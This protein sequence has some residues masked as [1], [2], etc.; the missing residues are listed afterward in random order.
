MNEIQSTKNTNLTNKS[1][2][3]KQLYQ[4]QIDAINHLLKY[5]RVLFGL[6]MGLGKTF[7]SL[8]WLKQKRLIDQNQ[9]W[10]LIICQAN[11]RQDWFNE[12]RAAFFDHDLQL[13]KQPQLLKKQVKN[14]ETIDQQ[15]YRVIVIESIKQLEQLVINSRNQQNLLPYLVIDGYYQKWIAGDLVN[16]LNDLQRQFN[17]ALKT[18]IITNNTFVIC[19]YAV[20]SAYSK[21]HRYWTKHWGRFGLIF[22]ESQGLR[23]H[24]SQISMAMHYEQFYCQYL[25]LLSGDP[26]PN[27]YQDWYRQLAL[28]GLNQNLS[29]WQWR[30]TYLNLVDKYQHHVGKT[31]QMLDPKQPISNENKLVIDQLI[32]EQIYLLNA[33]DALDL[34]K[35]IFIEHKLTNE[36]QAWFNDDEVN[37]IEVSQAYQQMLDDGYLIVNCDLKQWVKENRINHLIAF[38]DAELVQIKAARMQLGVLNVE[39][40]GPDISAKL[41]QNNLLKIGAWYWIDA[42]K[43]IKREDM[44]EADA[45]AS[46][47]ATT[48]HPDG[49][50][51][52]LAPM[53]LSNYLRQISS[54]FIKAPD[55]DLIV[56]INEQKLNQLL[57]I[58]NEI[59]HDERIVI[60]Y[61]FKHDIET[62]LNHPDLKQRYIVQ[63]N[64]QVNDFDPLKD[65]YPPGT[66]F[67][68]Q[69]QSG[70]KGI[71]GLQKWS[72][73][74]IYYNP[75]SS[76]E[77]WSQ[78]QAR[79]HRIGQTNHCFYHLIISSPIEM[80]MYKNLKAK[81]DVSLK[82]FARFLK[83]T[84][85]S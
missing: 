36:I 13:V 37:Q 72:Q 25:A 44:F 47:N 17:Q 19:S 80:F 67:C 32:K 31:I 41:A 58:L 4:F 60:F 65:N 26:V 63:I 51:S 33:K 55:L 35:Q 74:I 64:G 45:W 48:Y 29:Y 46:A 66:L 10:N 3:A 18:W 83:Q 16:S 6:D 79:I 24:K 14:I 9:C 22:D 81:Q 20:F 82:M 78:S 59:H 42:D 56:D 52:V 5:N 50:I 77:L 85:T 1:V 39:L 68:I 43:T 54:G 71:D 61:N 7:T 27:G 28:L 70:A 38:S 76:A 57:N 23:D 34:P 73:R 12:I 15:Q 2:V 11:K 49:S 40:S 84:K 62:F 8:H 53:V 69:Y 75:T 21:K 30:Q